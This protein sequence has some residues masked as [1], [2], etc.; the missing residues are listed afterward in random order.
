MSSPH[1]LMCA[2]EFYGIQYEINPWMN[3]ERKTDHALAVQQWA[4][5]REILESLGAK[6]SLQNPQPDLPDLVF[7]ANAALVFKNRA[8]ISRFR[9]EQRQ[10][11]EQHN[12]AWLFWVPQPKRIPSDIAH[13]MYISP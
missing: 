4:A 13:C 7:T 12:K 10:G 11:E 6:V 5:L 8:I 9:H 3:L 1:L 2:P